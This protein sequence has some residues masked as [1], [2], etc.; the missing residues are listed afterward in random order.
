[1]P[2][3]AARSFLSALLLLCLGVAAGWGLRGWL[4]PGPEDRSEP[5]A[6]TPVRALPHAQQATPLRAATS[7]S[8]AQTFTPPSP[9]PAP[10][11]VRE[12]P[13][14][15]PTSTIDPVQ[16]LR[17]QLDQQQFSAAMGI[18]QEVERRSSRR[19]M[20]LRD[21]I[22]D[23]L[24]GYLR[25]GDDG[26]LTA[27]AD[28]FLSV[29][30]DDIDVLLILARHQQQSDYRAEAARTFQLIY[31]YSATQPGQR[32]RVDRAF[33]SF[34]HQVDRQLAEQDQWTALLGFYNM[35]EQLDLDRA[36]ERLRLAELHL[37]YGSADYGR[38]LLQA[39]TR[40]PALG[41]RATAL[42][43]NREHVARPS[44]L[45]APAMEGSVPLESLGHHYS[46]PVTLDDQSAIRLVIDTGAS[47]TTL[48]QRS[49]EALAQDIRFTEVGPQLFNTANGP[50]RGMVYRVAQ[51]R[52]GE[53]QLN[54]VPVAVLDFDAPDNIDGLLGMNVLS[55]FRFE[56]DQD[57]HRLLLQP[58]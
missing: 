2:R 16:R 24:K 14:E 52:L 1:M 20:P 26:A 54:N 39:L 15:A 37:H 19:A 29:H 51:L 22:L 46:L 49:F 3:A 50:S 4:A 17:Q 57:A 56:V 13:V 41:Q 44:R 32:S 6:E 53:H 8:E 45:P 38:Q 28:R 5:V 33:E 7:Q 25:S 30:Y 36:E 11:Y 9:R 58:R 35:L 23:Y 47:L 34:V 43:D 10:Q 31:A 40:H 27:L 55:Q 42:L 48:T 18:Y 12:A 21:V